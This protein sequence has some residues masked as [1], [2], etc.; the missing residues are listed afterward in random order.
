MRELIL[1][2]ILF[3]CTAAAVAEPAA[4]WTPE[5]SM[6]VRGLGAVIPSPDG[7]LVVW[8]ETQNV[9]ETEKSETVTQIWLARADGSRRIALT[10]GEKSSLAPA[11]SPDGRLVYFRSS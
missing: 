3:A 7:T 6:K 9:I 2:L 4:Q 10:R 8:T 1:V 5:L 11:F